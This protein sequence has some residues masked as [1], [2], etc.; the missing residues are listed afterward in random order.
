[1]LVIN[2]KN[3]MKAIIVARVSTEEQKEAGHSLPAQIARMRDYC[4]KNNLQIVKTH[5][6]DETGYKSSRRVEFSQIVDNINEYTEKIVICFDK[7]DRLSRDI[8][9]KSV[10]LLYEKAVSDEIELHFVSDSQVINNTMNAGDKFMFGIKLGLSKYYS[11]AIS[12]NVRRAFEQLRREGKWLGPAPLG[13]VN[14]DKDLIIDPERGHLVKKAF[15][16]YSTGNYSITSLRDEVTRLGLITKMGNVVAR[17]TIADMLKNSFYYGTAFSP[18]YGPYNHKYPRLITKELFDKCQEVRLG[19]SNLPSKILSRDY[20][21]KG[22]LK[23]KKCGCSITPEY[24]CKPSGKEYVFYSCTNA[25]RICKREYINEQDLLK[26]IYEVLKSF[27]NISED[28]QKELVQE[29]RKT[30]DAEIE[31]HKKQV[32]R[33]RKD[34]D[35]VKKRDDNLLNALIAE[36]I[37]KDVYDKKH[38]E[39][40]DELQRLEI[41]LSEHRIADYDYQTTVSTVLSVA[42]RAMEIFENCSEPAEKRTFLNYILQN[43]TLEGKKLEFN[44][45]SPFDTILE[46]ANSPEWLCGQDSNLQPTG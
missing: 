9:D 33:I 12:D 38:Q 40:A 17:S 11:D 31:F 21:F 45:A 19:R 42:R 28:I 41:E 34:Y 14:I 4:N 35:E 24:K 36:S 15:E 8:F 43:P 1:M 16:L 6:F 5:S 27:S 18:K 44:L 29:L 25:K 39:L 37:T 32:N 46:L 20:I 3:L 7:V 22:L 2:D 23:C 30:T 13:Y 10:A 26:P